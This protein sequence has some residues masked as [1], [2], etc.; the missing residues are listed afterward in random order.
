[1]WMENSNPSKRTGILN[2]EFNQLY[3]GD[4]I[5]GLS[6][7]EEGSVD[8]AFA[9]PPFNI[10]YEYDVY[11]DSKDRGNG[12]QRSSAPSSRPARSGLPSETSSPRS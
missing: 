4:C 11:N 3:Q 2:V 10:G 5:A 12:A 8:L 6:R 1:M 9:D 7:L